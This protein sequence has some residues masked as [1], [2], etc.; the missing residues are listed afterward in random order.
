MKAIKKWLV[1]N[2]DDNEEDDKND[3]K[4]RI[5]YETLAQRHRRRM[6]ILNART[7]YKEIVNIRE[8]TQTIQNEQ[9]VIAKKYNL[10]SVRLDWTTPIEYIH[11][12]DDKLEENAVAFAEVERANRMY[13]F[14]N[15]EILLKGMRSRQE[16]VL[17]GPGSF[18]D[19]DDYFRKQQRLAYLKLK[20]M[21]I[22]SQEDAL[23]FA[24]LFGMNDESRHMLLKD[25]I[26]NLIQSARDAIE[27]AA[28]GGQLSY[29]K[30]PS[31]KRPFYLEVNVE[32]IES[33]ARA[34]AMSGYSHK[35]A[36]GKPFLYTMAWH[37]ATGL[38]N[39]GV[40]FGTAGMAIVTYRH[41]VGS[42]L[43]RWLTR[44][45]RD[46]HKLFTNG[47]LRVYT[48][49]ASCKHASS[50]TDGLRLLF[51]NGLGQA[52]EFTG[53]ML[54]TYLTAGMAP[55]PGAFLGKFV[56][57]F[58]VTV[59]FKVIGNVLVT[60]LKK[61]SFLKVSDETQKRIVA[62]SVQEQYSQ[63]RLE[64]ERQL[65]KTERSARLFVGEGT[66][67][68]IIGD[69]IDNTMIPYLNKH[70]YMANF[71]LLAS[72]NIISQYG[73]YAFV[74]ALEV[75]ATALVGTMPWFVQNLIGR[76]TRLSQWAVD[77][78]EKDAMHEMVSRMF[79]QPKLAKIVMDRINVTY[80]ARRIL[81][82]LNLVP[83]EELTASKF[84]SFQWTWSL[85]FKTISYNLGILFA[86]FGANM[87]VMGSFEYNLVGMA[88]D[89]AKYF[90]TVADLSQDKLA[91][92]LQMFYSSLTYSFLYEIIFGAEGQW[93]PSQGSASA[94]PSKESEDRDS[95]DI[96]TASLNRE[97]IFNVMAR[98]FKT[99]KTGT[100]NWIQRLIQWFENIQSRIILAYTFLNVDS[101]S[102]IQ[103]LPNNILVPNN[104]DTLP[105]SIPP[106]LTHPNEIQALPDAGIEELLN[107]AKREPKIKEGPAR[108][109][110]PPLPYVDSDPDETA[111]INLAYGVLNV[112]DPIE[113][114]QNLPNNIAQPQREI[115]SS[116]PYLNTIQALPES[117][118]EKFKTEAER[119][120]LLELDM[121][122]VDKIVFDLKE[123]NGFFDSIQPS[124]QEAVEKAEVTSVGDEL[125]IKLD[126]NQKMDE[127][128]FKEDVQELPLGPYFE[129]IKE[130]ATAH[131]VMKKL[132]QET[133]EKKEILENY[134]NSDNINNYQ[135]MSQ[136]YTDNPTT[137]DFSVDE[138]DI[139]INE[140][141]R[142]A[143]YE[144][145][146]IVAAIAEQQVVKSS[147][148]INDELSRVSLA[149]N[150]FR[151]TPFGFSYVPSP[152]SENSIKSVLE[153]G[154]AG[155][156]GFNEYMTNINKGMLFMNVVNGGMDHMRERAKAIEDFEL[157]LSTQ[158][159]P[160]TNQK[161]NYNY[162]DDVGA[163]IS[164]NILQ[165]VPIDYVRSWTGY[166]NGQFLETWNSIQ[167]DL[168]LMIDKSNDT[169]WIS[170]TSN[171]AEQFIQKIK[172]VQWQL[173][174][175]ASKLN[176][177]RGNY[178][179][180]LLFSDLASAEMMT[181]ELKDMSVSQTEVARKALKIAEKAVL[182]K[183]DTHKSKIRDM[184]TDWFKLGD[185]KKDKIA[186]RK[187][188]TLLKNIENR[189]LTKNPNG[190]D[191]VL[192]QEL[193][194]IAD[195]WVIQKDLRASAGKINASALQVMG[196]N[197]LLYGGEKEKAYFYYNGADKNL[198]NPV[199]AVLT[200]ARE[201]IPTSL[202]G[203]DRA[204]ARSIEYFERDPESISKYEFKYFMQ[205]KIR[206]E[207]V[208]IAESAKS[209][210]AEI[211]EDLSKE[212]K[213]LS[214]DLKTKYL[215]DNNFSETHAANIAAKIMQEATPSEIAE[216]GMMRASQRIDWLFRFMNQMRFS[217]NIKSQQLFDKLAAFMTKLTTNVNAENIE[218]VQSL[219]LKWSPEILMEANNIVEEIIED[220]KDREGDLASNVLR[221]FLI[222][223][224]T[225][226]IELPSFIKMR[227]DL[228][229]YIW[230]RFIFMAELYNS[231]EPLKFSTSPLHDILK[232]PTTAFHNA[233]KTFGGTFFSTNTLSNTKNL[234]NYIKTGIPILD[235]LGKYAQ[236]VKDDPVKN[237]FILNASR[238]FIIRAH[239][240]IQKAKHST[241]L[242]TNVY[243]MINGE[244]GR[245]MN[246]WDQK[247]SEGEPD[248]P[249]G[250]APLNALLGILLN[251]YESYGKDFLSGMYT[252][253]ESL[254]ELRSSFKAF[255]DL[256]QKEYEDSGLAAEHRETRKNYLIAHY[257]YDK[258]KFEEEEKLRPFT[259]ENMYAYYRRF[260][261]GV[262]K[263]AV[264]TGE[265]FVN[266]MH[267]LGKSMYKFIIAA[268]KFDNL[269]NDVAE[270]YLI[271]LSHQNLMDNNV[272]IDLGSNLLL[273]DDTTYGKLMR[274]SLLGYIPD[275]ISDINSIG[276]L[277]HL[278]AT[279]NYLGY[280]FGITEVTDKVKYGKGW[281]N[282]FSKILSSDKLKTI[283]LGVLS[284]KVGKDVVIGLLKFILPF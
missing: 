15:M 262:S 138:K 275:K 98:V 53:V 117:I 210:I 183:F 274:T 31:E 190:K 157:I 174:Q 51:T 50:V 128:I 1:G 10:D 110:P 105:D 68:D 245:D 116:L 280:Q 19:D 213:Y 263:R 153:K 278:R 271:N 247:L 114:I 254:S 96:L 6:M 246:V 4:N 150:S 276:I 170:G 249:V 253:A 14:D 84:I 148:S 181:Q 264:H 134:V 57:Q 224:W 283:G 131:T 230:N 193:L 85:L 179:G 99:F 258:D 33:H 45:Q 109:V 158:I 268:R 244:Q 120:E 220:V 112:K 139:I 166:M 248:I 124:L 100:M 76:V 92:L 173:N 49:L 137:L 168:K 201:G 135:T 36:A 239:D 55:I 255:S 242:P 40:A 232:D 43:F 23:A 202:P 143:D 70:N 38:A 12:R 229:E 93:S 156:E 169:D 34:A 80:W 28:K 187:A 164:G 26:E 277:D 140:A 66:I 119:K 215:L 252:I 41:G 22:G 231:K 198:M 243:H 267:S 238:K 7:T 154:Q 67:F 18:S 191:L 161:E 221:K 129:K 127:D 54:F 162:Q 216:M 94:E 77:Y 182:E 206:D 30:P 101:K 192:I 149:Y 69:Y 42:N 29:K 200:K 145:R 205:T 126:E 233:L 178:V 177:E 108:A 21:Y 72:A 207:A 11:S 269:G 171:N 165:S 132:V 257:K 63:K 146:S 251:P 223:P 240:V 95:E 37:M 102:V 160:L 59:S 196:M 5:P 256:F 188:D 141:T 113:A 212:K 155:A 222:N 111:R 115:I 151:N 203:V 71:L 65:L 260:I 103:D 142:K 273:R 61:I 163:Y 74:D 58:I 218:K 75:P 8:Q 236:F 64:K 47:F 194:K 208:K 27:M 197:E 241:L 86:D 3:L 56:L 25:Q 209:T 107:Q 97:F 144:I 272:D 24:K 167:D 35:I 234:Y 106:L 147:P 204:I 225:T 39:V 46:A 91:M 284:Q 88:Q 235:S 118:Q 266:G 44:D 279:T 152:S 228:K 159:L 136:P 121:E 281:E 185:M 60:L 261:I 259:I 90:L 189:L 227:E 125:K 9:D 17:S 217:A 211:E 89:T 83:K 104:M 32:R 237:G 186:L 20:G 130:L 16:T 195:M 87:A 2:E 133:E 48:V 270:N 175:I 79:I 78:L 172:E 214:L 81:Q 62:A 13:E 265:N 52:V 282:M 122:S 82:F 199:Q 123:L 184:Y 219:E 180:S 226:D 176:K 73:T 250:T